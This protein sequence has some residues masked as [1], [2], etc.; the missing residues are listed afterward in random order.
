[1]DRTLTTGAIAL[2][3]ACQ[4]SH[5]RAAEEPGHE[6]AP[7]APIALH[8]WELRPYGGWA[9]VPSSLTAGFVGASTAVRV[10]PRWALDLD[11]AWYA[12]F[13]AHPGPSPAYPLNET[14]WS[15]TV[16]AAFFPFV[17][18]PRGHGADSGAFEAWVAVGAGLVSTRPVPVVDPIHRHFDYRNSP[19]L[20]AGLGGR[21][22]LSHVLAITLELRDLFYLE[23]LENPNVASGSGSLPATDP[24]SPLNRSTWLSVN[25]FT[26]AP[27]LRIGASVF[28][29]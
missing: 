17:A 14:S 16:G 4:Q 10:H 15:A 27:E 5:A 26:Q 25:H 7:P 18:R 8:R 28:L 2:A 29:F 13:L 3:I 24:N 22:Y 11:G 6:V 12:P 19:H 9:F 21:V 23:S 1:M 20:A